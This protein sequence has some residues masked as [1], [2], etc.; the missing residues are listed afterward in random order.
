MDRTDWLLI[1]LTAAYL[2]VI[3]V[4]VAGSNLHSS[5]ERVAE[6]DVWLLLTSALNVVPELDIPQWILL[7]ASITV[8]VWRC[9]P[10][11]WWSVALAGHV[12]A[13]L[14]SYLVI[15]LAV[16]IGSGSADTTAAESDYGISIILAATL[17]A[18][19]ASGFAVPS[20][21]RTR[22][23][24]VSIVLGLIGL[25][26]MI[27]FSVGWYDM[28]HVIGYAIGFVLTGWLLDRGTFSWTRPRFGHGSK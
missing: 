28:Q 20:S 19:A 4:G 24:R 21:A 3:A 23:D 14:I 27:A 18:L 22:G 9:G 5:A 17:G 10:K 2:V 11:L 16:A 7:A 1:F 6:G 26:G 25:A 15:G 13:A 8:V 12:G